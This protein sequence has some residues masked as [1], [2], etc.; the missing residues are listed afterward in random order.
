M[1]KFLCRSLSVILASFMIFSAG[2]DK[3]D[4]SDTAD[5][6]AV[7]TS[8]SGVTDDPNVGELKLTQTKYTETSE[9]VSES[10]TLNLDSIAAGAFSQPMNVKM[11]RGNSSSAQFLT[12]CVSQL[13]IIKSFGETSISTYEG[14]V[15][16]QIAGRGWD[17]LYFGLRNT[18]YDPT[19][20]EGVWFVIN[21]ND[22]GLRVGTWPNSP[23]NQYI[24]SPVDFGELCRF[25]VVDDPVKN[26]I[27]FYVFDDSNKEILAARVAIKGDESNATVEF[28]EGNSTTPA[29]TNNCEVPK[30]GQASFWC[31]HPDKGQ[32]IY[33]KNFTITGSSTVIRGATTP[34]S[35]FT[36]DVFAD[37]WVSTTGS[38]STSSSKKSSSNSSSNT[39]SSKSS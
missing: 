20:N 13:R 9:T 15:Q 30:S 24:S 33:V 35:L 5:S 31:H 29:F 23:G 1:K 4:S 27:Y 38:T 32:K 12:D 19:V 11:G 2:C 8:P 10:Y 6:G 17:A 18:G 14:Q 3:G 36:K 26:E 16:C 34:D 25:R 7:A 22:I 37:T 39:S 21:Q 28:Y